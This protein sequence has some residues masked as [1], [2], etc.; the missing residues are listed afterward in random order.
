MRVELG[1]VGD[2]GLFRAG[3]PGS[4]RSE[5]SQQTHQT[6]PTQHV[7]EGDEQVAVGEAGQAKAGTGTG[8]G[9]ETG[10]KTGTGQ[11]THGQVIIVQA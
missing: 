11:E 1:I 7:G 6:Q 5:Q 3:H 4:E 2:S 8:T 9:T 10:T